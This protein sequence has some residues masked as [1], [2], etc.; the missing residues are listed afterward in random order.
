MRQNMAVELLIFCLFG[1]SH[2][3]MSI[4]MP[5]VILSL[6]WIRY[7]LL[8]NNGMI[9][10]YRTPGFNPL[11]FLIT[12]IHNTICRSQW[13]RGLRRG[14]TAAPLLGLL[15]RIPPRAWMSVFCECCVLWGRGL[16]VGLITRLEE[17]YRVWCV[18]VWS[19]S[20]KQWGGLGPQGAVEP[21]K[22]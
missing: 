20:L 7:T 22:K 8:E 16:C 5:S 10:K 12:I 1:E 2:L 4:E 14:S 11:F 15:V 3:R 13:P 9:P 17:S 19:W 18:W 6:S 21:L